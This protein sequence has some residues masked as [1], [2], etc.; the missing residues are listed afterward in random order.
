[1]AGI[2]PVSCGHET[3]GGVAKVFSSFTDSVVS[4]FSVL[5]APAAE[6]GVSAISGTLTATVR[7]A[8]ELSC[9]DIRGFVMPLA[10]NDHESF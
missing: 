2:S 8:T 9:F 6:L 3:G 10:K 4:T 5:V 1:M 7:A